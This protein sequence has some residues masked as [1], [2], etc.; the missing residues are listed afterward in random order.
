MDMQ[1]QNIKFQ[2]K[3]LILQMDNIE[4]LQSQNLSSQN[5]KLQLTNM[6]NSND[7]FGISNN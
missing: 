3:N 5:L 2:L 1:I 7:E 4:M 6:G